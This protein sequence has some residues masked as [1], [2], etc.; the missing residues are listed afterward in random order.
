MWNGNTILAGRKLKALGFL[1]RDRG[2]EV[3]NLSPRLNSTDPRLNESGFQTVVF[4]DPQSRVLA[5]PMI[6][7]LLK[8]PKLGLGICTSGMF[9][10]RENTRQGFSP[11]L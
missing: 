8:F 4:A 10:L 9:K 11:H 5:L 2:A 1:S 7:R 6:S 3:Q